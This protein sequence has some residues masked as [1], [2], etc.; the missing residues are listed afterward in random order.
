M[1]IGLLL[2][3]HVAVRFQHIAGDYPEMFS[4]WLGRCAPQLHLEFFDVCSGEFPASLDA[5]EA[6]MTTGSKHSVYEDVAWIHALKN[7][8]RQLHKAKKPFIGICFGH[9][10]L[11][12]ALGGK[13]AKSAQGWGVGVHRTEIV[14]PELWL[15]PQPSGCHLHYMHQDQVQRLPDNAVIIGRSK[16][17]PIA[18]LRVDKS[19]LGI[20]AHPEFTN[21]YSEALLLDRM[22]RIGAERVAAARKSL[23][24]KTDE[25]LITK[26]ITE[27]IEQN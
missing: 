16:H 7:F 13:V 26:W 17:C 9:Q 10:M 19:M 6:Y 23:T 22:E 12:E 18:M 21:A 11:A 1:K 8:V 15:Q 20:Q 14:Q 27:F 2:C 24:Q 4:A 5:C 25:D 3:D